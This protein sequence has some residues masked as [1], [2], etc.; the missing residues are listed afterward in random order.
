MGLPAKTFLTIIASGAAL[1]Y[2]DLTRHD[3]LKHITKISRLEQENYVWLDKF[4]IRNLELFQPL[5]EGGK[6]LI[7]V[8]DNT[9][10]PM[11][12]RMLK[13]WLALPLKNIQ[14]INERLN[15]VQYFIEQ[16]DQK[17]TIEEALGRICRI[18]S[19]E[20]NWQVYVARTY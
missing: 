18:F 3:Q 6:S 12:S 15:I 11:G 4:T 1:Y 5:N 17:K 20:E 2:L 19:S 16:Q 13:R 7:D 8:I 14:A 9:I 10:S